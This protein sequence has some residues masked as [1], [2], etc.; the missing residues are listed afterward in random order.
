MKEKPQLI[1]GGKRVDGR[2]FNELRKIS[3]ET[4]VIKNADGS[5][6]LR[7]GSNLVIAAVYGPKEALPRHTA[8]PDRAVIKCR[9][10]MAPF[11]SLEEH[12]RTGT[13]RRSTEISKVTRE[14]FESVVMLERFPGCEINIFIEVLQSDGGTRAAGITA[15]AVALACSGVPIR[16]IPYAVSVGKAGEHLI[17]DLN[18]LEDTQSDAD[19]PVAISP[20]TGDVLLL[21]MDGSLTDAEFKRGM[22]MIKEAGKEIVSLQRAALERRYM[23]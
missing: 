12:G 10:V 22:T 4:D 11:S 19:M 9:Y 13:N 21:Q 8:N 15:A 23:R 17:L 18:K 1:V 16:D 20:R 3:I 5:A 2:A 6:R 14:V 7:W